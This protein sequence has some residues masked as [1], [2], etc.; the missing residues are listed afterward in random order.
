MDFYVEDRVLD[1]GV[2]IVFVTINDIDKPWKKGYHVFHFLGTE[3]IAKTRKSTCWQKCHR[4]NVWDDDAK[5]KQK[6]R[7]VT[8][9]YVWCRHQDDTR[10]NEE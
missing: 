10:H 5:G 4:E 7:T 1:I 2:K 9:E 6:A 3:Y 8:H